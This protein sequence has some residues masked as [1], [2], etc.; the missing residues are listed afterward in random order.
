M[1]IRS[2]FSIGLAI[3]LT[4]VVAQI[5]AIN[6]FIEEFQ[7]ATS[8]I[9]RAVRAKETDHAVASALLGFRKH[10]AALEST[11]KPGEVAPVLDL[12]WEA[13][14]D[15]VK[16]LVAASWVE[17]DVDEAIGGVANAFDASRAELAALNTALEKQPSVDQE[18]VSSRQRL[19][20]R[21]DEL[22][23]SLATADAVLSKKVKAALATERTIHSHPTTAAVTIGLI[24]AIL[25]AIAIS[26]LARSVTRSIA[27]LSERFRDV[28]QGEADLTHRVDDTR[29]DELGE[30]GKWFNTFVERIETIIGEIAESSRELDD[31]SQSVGRSSRSITQG[32]TTQAENLQ[33]IGISLELITS[34]T[35]KNADNARKAARLARDSVKSA[36]QGQVVMTEMCSAMDEIKNSSADIAN[37]IRVIDDIASQT[38]L[39]ALN[40]AVEAARAGESGLGFAVVAQEVRSL[41]QR[42]A[43]AARST[44]S[45]IEQAV[46]RAD[47][48]VEIA[49]RV[50]LTLEEI[51]KCT[52]DVTE[53]LNDIAT[54][55]ADQAGAVEQVSAGVNDLGDVTRQNAT[56]SEALAA[57][58]RRVEIQAAA[59]QSLVGQFKTQIR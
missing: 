28:A 4:V 47:S 13:V 20:K 48:G 37:V 33:Q 58:A 41:A 22:D 46:G 43:E 39:L 45:M 50:G 19:S 27:D 18:I 21:L 6:V 9:T 44:E 42:S 24:G 10:V 23:G 31:G 5:V 25:S 30:L 2:S 55:S 54:A 11:E 8:A 12:Q 38:N 40:A 57:T 56:A 29:A 51:V 35:H 52:N 59:M 7:T 1:T 3:L 36:D 53:L 16:H 26:F 34:M 32:A 14:A 15:A 17:A 49:A